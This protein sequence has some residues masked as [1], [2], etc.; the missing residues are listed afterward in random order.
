MHA[1]DDLRLRSTLLACAITALT[2]CPG[3][4]ASPA[5]T[6]GS[7][8]GTTGSTSAS[9]SS[10]TDG[11]TS[12]GDTTSNGTTPNGTTS[13]ATTA[14]STGSDESSSGATPT[15]GTTAADASSGDSTT[16]G[17]VFDACDDSIDGALPLVVTG[18]TSGAGDD[19]APSCA[20]VGAPELAFEWTVPATGV[21]RLDT[22]GSSF[23]TTL[24]LLDACNAD[25]AELA[26]NDDSQELLSEL[27]VQLTQDQTVAIVVDGFQGGSQGEFEL[28]ITRIECT[29]DD[30]GMTLP[31]TVE[32]DTS[33]AEDGLASSCGGGGAP[34]L[35]YTWAAPVA[36]LFV[37]DTLGSSIAT[38]LS[39][40][41]GT[42]G[43]PAS[44]V[45]CDSSE[46]DLPA[47]VFVGLEAGESVS[48]A[49]DGLTAEDAGAAVPNIAQVGELAGDCCATDDS[50]GCE[51][52][53]VTQ[54]VCGWSADCC[55]GE[56]TDDC[57]ELAGAACGADCGTTSDYGPE[58]E[59]WEVELDFGPGTAC[60]PPCGVDD[61]CVPPS[62]GSATATCG[63]TV[64][65]LDYCLLECDP[66]VPEPCP[67]GAEC[68]DY[69]GD[70]YMIC[71]YP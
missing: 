11:G 41:G 34:D 31:V 67:A 59:A 70:G 64:D 54:C 62:G 19:S 22:F 9:T 20:G 30:L 42:C 43:D 4:A 71:A 27:V 56:W 44:L 12:T 45:T 60:L 2:G 39:V 23:D 3:D 14:A 63:A 66:L 10:S 8:T 13:T 38:A 15:D 68:T 57:A 65:G 24:Y 26:C 28:H 49:V 55:V 47:Q 6:D 35:E 50:A 48:I 61:S 40:Y 52:A 29:S 17:G 51:G 46:G 5:D 21:Y 32:L 25:G 36:G 18:D 69:F 58:C 37:I 33:G 16:G 53:A 7:S 1:H